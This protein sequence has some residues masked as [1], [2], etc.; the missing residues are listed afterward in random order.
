MYNTQ[1]KL[2]KTV[3]DDNRLPTEINVVA[4]GN[5]VLLISKYIDTL[6]HSYRVIPHFSM[7]GSYIAS[8]VNYNPW[9]NF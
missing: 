6:V 2:N 4:T 3:P 9:K 1:K 7:Y 5:S 8:F